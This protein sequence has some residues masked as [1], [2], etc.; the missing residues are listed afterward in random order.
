MIFPRFT[1]ASPKYN[2]EETGGYGL[3]ISWPKLPDPIT[4][5][6]L[7]TIADDDFYNSTNNGIRAKYLFQLLHVV[8]YHH[9]AG[10]KYLIQVKK[11]V[12]NSILI[13]RRYYIKKRGPVGV[14]PGP[15]FFNESDGT[16]GV[17]YVPRV[18]ALEGVR[19]THDH[20]RW[21]P[22]GRAFNV[23][24]FHLSEWRDDLID[25]CISLVRENMI[26]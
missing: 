10:V 13:D 11:D 26:E 21:Y 2:R 7:F 16:V 1:E 4:I 18:Y 3:D 24:E 9:K 8:D 15:R 25:R 23:P 17:M 14:G 20:V 12:Q 19:F 22:I 6:E 5:D